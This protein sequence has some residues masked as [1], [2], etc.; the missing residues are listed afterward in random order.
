[1]HNQRLDRLTDYPFQRL[2]ALLQDVAPAAGV[3]PI[4]MHIGEPHHTP[5][6]FVSQIL[7]EH[8][9]DWGRYPPSNG[10]PE[11]RTAIADWLTRRYALPA[12]FVDPDTHVQPVAGSREGLFMAALATVPTEQPRQPAVLMPNPLYQAY[13]GAAVVSGAEPVLVDATLE[14]GFQP[15][16]EE[17]APDLLDRTALAFIN[18]PANPQGSVL[19]LDRLRALVTLA[20]RHDFVLAFDECYGEIYT[21][22]APAGGLQACAALGDDI[23]N[24][25]VFNSLSKR[26]SV[27]GLRSGFIAGDPDLIR[28]IRRLRDYGGATLPMPVMAASAAL[29]ADENHVEASRDLYRRKFGIAAELLNGHAGTQAPG[30]SFFLWLNVG[31][32]EAA[33]QRLWQE[34]AI[35]VLPGAFLAHQT[36]RGNPGQPFVRLALVDDL[37]TT[38]RAF[39]RLANTLPANP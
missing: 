35:R 32:S 5:P 22:E 10:T 24:V 9:K 18:S 17:L 30:G 25:L 29:W 21:S 23:S 38:H 39:Q 13:I 16:Y 11:L 14:N 12:D 37:D 3:E 33:A 34:A 20:R 26:S 1:M 36:E 27:P 8:A 19:S 2:R 6:A 31:D 7:L 4:A 15:N 28:M